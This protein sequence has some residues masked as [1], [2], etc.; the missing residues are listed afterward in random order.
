[1][2]IDERLERIEQLLQ[3]SIQPPEFYSIKQA[4]KVVGVSTDHI[5]RAVVGGV[6]A[7][8][9][10]GT[11]ARPT[12]RIARIDLLARVARSASAA[13]VP[14]DSARPM[15]ILSVAAAS[16]GARPSDD[17]TVPTGGDNDRPYA[18]THFLGA[19][20]LAGDPD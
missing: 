17:A 3:S 7:A 19:F 2:N 6:L 10:V 15:S 8:S 12:Y 4:A 11:M 16:Y 9:N 13:S 20:V 18:S 5:R 14:L 1:M